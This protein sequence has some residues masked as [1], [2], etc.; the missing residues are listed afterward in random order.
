MLDR[1][2]PQVT[3]VGAWTS[4]FEAE[5]ALPPRRLWREVDFARPLLTRFLLLEL[6]PRGEN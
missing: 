2:L 1:H 4:C 3:L 6:E 5:A